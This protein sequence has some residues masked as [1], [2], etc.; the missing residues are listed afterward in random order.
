MNENAVLVGVDG[1]L[2]GD[3][4]LG[5]AAAEA[6]RLHAPLSVCYAVAPA[7]VDIPVLARHRGADVLAAAVDRLAVEWPQL[8]VQTA[9]GEGYPS[10]ELLRRSA[11]HQLVA[12]GSRGDSGLA[13]IL[14]GTVAGHLLAHARCPVVVVPPNPTDPAAPVLLGVDG[15]ELN[16]PAV[17]FAFA[18]ADRRDVPLIALSALDTRQPRTGFGAAPTTAE[19]LIELTREAIGAWAQKY[20]HVPVEHRILAGPPARELVAASTA[21]SLTVVGSRGHGA[22][23]GLLLGSVSRR[24]SQQAQSPVAVVRKLDHRR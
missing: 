8:P 14:L 4:A 3:R 22:M 2:G 5:W 10:S 23:T 24:V 12:V 7:A 1:S 13:G 21:A 17:E 6:A 15:S 16:R 11:G 19:Q 20:P 9:L 18:A